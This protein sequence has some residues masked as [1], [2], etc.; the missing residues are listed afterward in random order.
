LFTA[1]L[2]HITTSCS[3]NP[4]TDNLWHEFVSFTAKTKPALQVN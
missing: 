1:D 4:W 3:G 2:S